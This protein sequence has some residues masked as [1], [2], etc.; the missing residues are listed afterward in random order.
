MI[1]RVI[2]RLKV[3][4]VLWSSG[5]EMVN[6]TRLSFYS[7]MK[8]RGIGKLRVSVKVLYCLIWREKAY[9]NWRKAVFRSRFFSVPQSTLYIFKATAIQISVLYFFF[10][11]VECLCFK[12]VSHS[13]PTHFHN[14]GFMQNIFLWIWVEISP[15]PPPLLQK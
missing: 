6:V 11:L 4:M 9:I 13:P 8:T 14:K 3:K 5:Q 10:F 15:P 12:K 7:S 2:A 1:T